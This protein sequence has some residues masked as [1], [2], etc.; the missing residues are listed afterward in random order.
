MVPPLAPFIEDEADEADD[1]GA[2]EA[3]ERCPD[4]FGLGAMEGA[5]AK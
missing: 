1:G 2:D 5:G 4:A 3:V